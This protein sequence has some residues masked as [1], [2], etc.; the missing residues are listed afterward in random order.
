MSAEPQDSFSSTNPE[1]DA[2]WL[3]PPI[4]SYAICSVARSGSTLLGSLLWDTGLAGK[5]LEYFHPLHAQR[6]IERWRS[7]GLASH[8]PLRYWDRLP[9]RQGLVSDLAIGRYVRDLV[10]YRTSGNGRFGF[11]LHYGQYEKQLGLRSLEPLFPNLRYVCINRTDRV[12]QAI[13]WWKASQTGQWAAGD[14]KRREASYSFSGILKLHC[15][16]LREEQAWDE[17]FQTCGVEPL[18]V[19]YEQ[20][21]SAPDA[22]VR[23]VLR[24]IDVTAE[25]AHV[26][27]RMQRQADP[28]TREWRERY[29]QTLELRGLRPSCVDGA[30]IHV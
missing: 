7:W 5:P 24:A 20:V 16:I 28:T 22:A 1:H 8:L 12:G 27:P 9:R 17:Y 26:K 30:E 2:E 4:V 21:A 15:E 11:K 6:L 10:R 29:V 23:A 3:G 19:T 18:R 25:P 14:P 13:S